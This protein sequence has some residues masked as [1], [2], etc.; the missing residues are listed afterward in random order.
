M[1]K[2][3]ERVW[4]SLL[5]I[6]FAILLLLTLFSNTIQTAMLPKVVTSQAAAKSLSYTLQ[7]S[8]TVTPK[9]VQF[10]RS[11]IS[12]G[13]AKITVKEQQT[14]KKG[15]ILLTF[16]DEQRKLLERQLR[17][18]EL[19]YD[20][21]QLQGELLQEQYVTAVKEADTDAIAQAKRD[22]KLHKLDLELAELKLD[23][24]R[25]DM[26]TS[27]QLVS[28]KAGIV[29]ELLVEE[30]EQVT[31]GQS[32]LHLIDPIEGYEITF[33]LDKPL[34][35]RLQLGQQLKVTI[36]EEQ[37]KQQKA[38]GQISDIKRIDARSSSSSSNE[39]VASTKEEEE[40]PDKVELAEVTLQLSSKEVQPS[41]I[42]AEAQLVDTLPVEEQGVVL[43]QSFVK[44]DSKGSY[45]LVVR[46]KKSSL[47][48]TYIADKVYV[49]IAA[50]VGDEV[51]I[52]RGLTADDKVIIEASEPIEAGNRVRIY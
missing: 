37:G 19:Q 48:N 32:V 41:W 15:D 51:M 2:R 8:G 21:Q 25:E 29:A 1:K 24:L 22:I 3:S 11:S 43:Q 9:A 35:D 30:G 46:E 13:I 14:V 33:V 28:E 27:R 49:T 47:G 23:T 31:N 45:V 52:T 7:S 10:I 36:Q 40:L 16:D 39:T 26:R 6:F 42:G 12:G 38:A 4:I 5:V 18:G 44:W 34:A 50:E 17:E 20:K